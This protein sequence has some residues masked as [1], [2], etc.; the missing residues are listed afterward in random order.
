MVEKNTLKAFP[1]TTGDKIY[2]KDQLKEANQQ[3]QL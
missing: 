2:T 3:G 1:V